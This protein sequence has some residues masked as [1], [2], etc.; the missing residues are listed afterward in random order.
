MPKSFFIYVLLFS[1][2]TLFTLFVVFFNK[3]TT[4]KH[5]KKPNKPLAKKSQ[6]KKTKRKAEV[7]LK[8]VFDFQDVKII[9]ED[10]TYTVYD[11][12]FVRNYST[13]P[14]KYKKMLVQFNRI[15]KNH[16]KMDYD[17]NIFVI[18]DAQGKRKKYKKYL[19]IPLHVRQKLP[20]V[21]KI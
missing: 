20:K 2:T 5:K 4:K 11:Q 15:P 13:L 7:S 14:S 19:D 10:K 16:F 9:Y 1:L 3:L 12:G 17:G 6:K 18:T 8:E 21:H